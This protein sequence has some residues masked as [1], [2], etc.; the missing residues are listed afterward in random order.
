MDQEFKSAGDD[1]VNLRLKDAIFRVS[2]SKV[3]A[4]V[5]V[6]VLLVGVFLGTWLTQRQQTYKSEASAKPVNITITSPKP[7]ESITGNFTIQAS[8]KTSEDTKRLYT[9]LKKDGENPES[10]RIRRIDSGTVGLSTGLNSKKFTPGSHTF[11]IYLYD[12][13]SGK[14][15]LVGQTSVKVVVK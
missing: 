5:G 9:V 8:A 7:G 2:R 13:S 15:I 6:V 10:L 11:D 1:E 12:L 3:I 4:L 14:P